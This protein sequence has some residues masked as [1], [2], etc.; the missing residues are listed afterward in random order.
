VLGRSK[1][2]RVRGKEGWEA[3]RERRAP[4]SLRNPAQG[5]ANARGQQRRARS[6]VMG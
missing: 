3:R 5:P 6:P 4:K 2:K 1:S